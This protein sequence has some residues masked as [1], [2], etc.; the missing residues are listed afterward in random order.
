VKS[1]GEI[2]CA[3][4]TGG[5][6][7]LGG[8]DVESLAGGGFEGPTAGTRAR[9]P[10]AHQA[11]PLSTP[12]ERPQAG[13]RPPST[14]WSAAPRRLV[15]ESDIPI[16]FGSG[17]SS[18]SPRLDRLRLVAEMVNMAG[19]CRSR[20]T[21]CAW[22]CSAPGAHEAGEG[23]ADRLVTEVVRTSVDGRRRGAPPRWFVERAARGLGTKMGIL[24]GLGLPTEY[25]EEI[26]AGYLSRRAE[27]RSQGRPARVRRERKPVWKAR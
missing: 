8:A 14:A 19:V 20:R 26:A 1:D 10:R 23:H 22:R 12:D 11:A 21:A 24:R 7:L 25:A 9:H 6:A 15:N 4:V 3:I 17:R 2:W 18:S 27:R 5:A 16:A 13:H